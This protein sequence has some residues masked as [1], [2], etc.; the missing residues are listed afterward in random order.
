MK[1]L[2][3]PLSHTDANYPARPDMDSWLFSSCLQVLVLMMQSERCLSMWRSSLIQTP[4]NTKSQWRVRSAFWCLTK[5]CLHSSSKL[6]KKLHLLSW[7]LKLTFGTLWRSSSHPFGGA[8]DILC[9]Q[10]SAQSLS[11]TLRFPEEPVMRVFRVLARNSGFHFVSSSENCTL[12]KG[13]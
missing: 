8:S 11:F 13:D 10:R 5:A 12:L 6:W 4:E 3:V 9:T 2:E 7:N 1:W